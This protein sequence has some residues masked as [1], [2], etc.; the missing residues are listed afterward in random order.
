M[1]FSLINIDAMFDKGCFDSH[2]NVHLLP[3]DYIFNRVN[4]GFLIFK[5]S[6][7]QMTGLKNSQ[8]QSQHQFVNGIWRQAAKEQRS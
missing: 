7:T 2:V 6:G 3:S 5:Y 1:S 4:P 8:E